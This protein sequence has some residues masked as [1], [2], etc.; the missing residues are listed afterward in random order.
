MAP[1]TKQLSQKEYLKKYLN[2]KK[3]KKPRRVNRRENVRLID[4]DAINRIDDNPFEDFE[5]GEDAPLI[6]GYYDE[7]PAEIK[8]LENYRNTNRWQPMPGAD[9]ESDDGRLS[10]SSKSQ[11]SKLVRDGHHSPTANRRERHLEDSRSRKRK[12]Q[13]SH[14]PSPPRSKHRQE[15]SPAARRTP[16][17]MERRMDER[18]GYSPARRGDH[19]KFEE[20]RLY[21]D[22]GPRFRDS[23]HSPGRTNSG[24]YN[25][26]S[27]GDRHRSDEQ[28]YDERYTRHRQRQRSADSGSPNYR[29][30]RMDDEFRGIMRRGDPRSSSFGERDRERCERPLSP[31]ARHKERPD[32]RRYADEDHRE[33]AAVDHRIPS[34]RNQRNRRNSDVESPSQSRHRLPN[35]GDERSFKAGVSHRHNASPQRNDRRGSPQRNDRRMSPPRNDRRPSPQRNDRRGSP[36][37]NDRRMSPPRNDR[38]PSP[39][40]NDRRMSPPRNDRRLS[41]QRNDRRGSPPRNDRRPS[42][43]RNDRRGSPQINERRFSPSPRENQDD[44]SWRRSFSPAPS[45]RIHSPM[46]ASDGRRTERRDD[47]SPARGLRSKYERPPSP[48]VRARKEGRR[49]DEDLSPPTHRRKDR[50]REDKHARD[51]KRETTDLPDIRDASVDS[52]IVQEAS[53]SR[54]HRDTTRD[55]RHPRE[56]LRDAGEHRRDYGESREAIRTIEWKEKSTTVSRSV[57]AKRVVDA[58]P[59]PRAE[60]SRRHETSP[61]PRKHREKSAV[62]GTSK[63]KA[64][65]EEHHRSGGKHEFAVSQPPSKHRVSKHESQIESPSPA[66]AMQRVSRHEPHPSTPPPKHRDESKQRT[67]S[68]KHDSVERDPRRRR[69]SNERT[70]G[71]VTAAKSADRTEKRSGENSYSKAAKKQDREDREHEKSEKSSRHKDDKFG[72][73]STKK[74][75]SKP[76]EKL[77]DEQAGKNAATIYRDAKTGKKRDLH[78]EKLE[79]IEKR[80]REDKKMEQYYKWGRGLKQVAEEEEKVKEE[81]Y[82]MSKP[83]ARYADDD[84]L[85]KTLKQKEI[86]GLDPMLEYIN[87]KKRKKEA[88]EGKVTRPQYKGSWPPNRF[89]IPPGHKWDG[90]DRSNGYESRYF[91]KQS[92]KKAMEEEAYKWCSEDM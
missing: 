31:V 23:D 11:K 80:R 91:A 4:D 29:N 75:S 90:V 13:S 56:T 89:N 62:A 6:A 73:L 86:S 69:T 57:P 74:S 58:A 41:P 81:E 71:A 5:D 76:E 36:Q 38:R 49:G 61:P 92:D 67:H 17:R 60:S 47:T 46:P 87:R 72:L 16:P 42:P 30:Q 40:R 19:G 2:K 22:L 33:F 48:S 64:V 63:K 12:Q 55:H 21:S 26:G 70:E 45:R 68:H 43:Q 37:R 25:G 52:Q 27:D 32:D 59:P 10:S 39:Q 88:K 66:A 18:G 83:L 24:R 65:A 20:Q 82:E 54:D 3:K 78:E 50:P 9:K 53:V 44:S 77:S 8:L 79:K 7:R 14:P 28:M 34:S 84:D 85:D 35:R 1:S 15:L 51:R